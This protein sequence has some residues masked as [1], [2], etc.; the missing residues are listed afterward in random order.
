MNCKLILTVG[1]ESLELSAPDSQTSLEDVVQLLK[2]NNDTRQKLADLLRNYLYTQGKVKPVSLSDL[3]QQ[4]GLIGNTDVTLLS[5]D[6]NVTFPEDV[7]P[8]I[9]L[10]NQLQIGGKQISGR[11]IDSNGEELFVVQ[12]SSSD[13]YKLANFLKTRKAIQEGVENML[14]DE[15]KAK[16][17]ACMEAYNKTTKSKKHSNISQ[18]LIHYLEN[19]SKYNNIKFNNIKA[20]QYLA[21]TVAAIL[22]MASNVKYDNPIIQEIQVRKK[23]I[24]GERASITVRDLYNML[25]QNMTDELKRF[26]PDDIKTETS[27][28]EFMSSTDELP[29]VFNKGDNRYEVLMNELLSL[30]PDFTYEYVGM[31]KNKLILHRTFKTIQEKYGI[32]YDTINEFK[33]VAQDYLGYKIYK[34]NVNGQDYYIASQGYLTEKHGVKR[35]KTLEEVQ[36]HIQD[37]INRKSIISQS[38]FNFKVQ[39]RHDLDI[40]ST[41]ETPQYLVEGSIIESIDI[42]LN[43]RQRFLPEE[44]NLIWRGGTMSQF[45]ALVN[46]WD[47]SDET[48]SKILDK[49]NTPEK[50]YIFISKLNE[51]LNDNRSDS[52]KI[53]NLVDNLDFNKKQAYYIAK[54]RS[55]EFG[56]YKYKIIPTEPNVVENYK[57]NKREPVIALIAQVG[58]MLKQKFGV[59]MVMMNSEELIKAFPG[60]DVNTTKA[61]IHDN[62]IYVNTTI[63]S[64]HDPLHEFAHLALGVMKT[65][66][67]ENYQAMMNRVAQLSEDSN[68]RVGKRLSQI[69]EAY[70]N[71]SQMDLLEE[72]FVSLFS[73]QVQ[74]GN[75]LSDLFQQ[76]QQPTEMLFN[77][78]IKD[79]NQFY[80]MTLKQVF[81]QF[82]NEVAQRFSQIDDNKIQFEDAQSS[83]KKSNWINKQIQDGNITE[84]CE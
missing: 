35:Y 83:R 13:V 65:N 46:N 2:S 81:T 62:K 14:S 9:L 60:M 68:S 84:N 26:M 45:V 77:T 6:F 53:G 82:N 4:Q 5:H 36:Q 43:Q 39:D 70:P 48:K 71:L 55:G 3:T 72:V 27:F 73:E 49:I 38:F 54:R 58:Q 12:N 40:Y 61:F 20:S 25:V 28:K 47:V 66:L 63:A 33:I 16:L 51:E 32:G 7:N 17:N 80:Q 23:M 22:G 74:F 79:L 31:D 24:N 69:K 52:D 56:G 10:V 76:L 34:Q 15:D 1:Q 75:G 18:M 19:K 44:E 30:E 41:K 78:K 8:H 29:G 64:V 59:E 42:P 50:V 11:I 37:T 57:Q 21:D 67:I